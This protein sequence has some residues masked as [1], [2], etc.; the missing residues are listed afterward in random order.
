[1]DISHDETHARFTLTIVE[2]CAF[3]SAFALRLHHRESRTVVSFLSSALQYVL[4]SLTPRMTSPRGSAFARGSFSMALYR[5]T[6]SPSV[7]LNRS[8][9][10]IFHTD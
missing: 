6:L 10:Q 2:D 4:F 5:F 7:G 9:R 1:M 8:I 3:S